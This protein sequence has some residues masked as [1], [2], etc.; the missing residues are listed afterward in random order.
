MRSPILALLQ[1][2]HDMQAVIEQARLTGKGLTPEQEKD[3]DDTITALRREE[4]VLASERKMTGRIDDNTLAA[5]RAGFDI[6]GGGGVGAHTTKPGR[7]RS[8]RDL[9]G[10]PRSSNGFG[11][12]EEFAGA[13]R[14][15]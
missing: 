5:A 6:G 11:S 15:S 7:G 9:F 13:V 12:L 14:T 10:A 8:F 1:K 3:F 4:A 2:K